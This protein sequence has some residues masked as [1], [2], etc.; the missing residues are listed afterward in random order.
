MKPHLFWIVLAG[1]VAPGLSTVF[2]TAEV[3]VVGGDQGRSWAGGGGTIPAVVIRT[4][5]SV[6]QTNAL[7]GVIDFN[8]EGRPN[9]IFPQRA[10]VT[11]NIAEGIAERGGD[12]G[13]NV[14]QIRGSLGRIIDDDGKTALD[15]RGLVG[16][17]GVRGLQIDMD[18]GARFGVDR[19]K[20]FPRNADPAYP[21][22]EFPFQNDFL[23]G[24]EIFVNDGTPENQS[25][26]V[27][28][29]HTVVLENKN[30]EAVV[31]VR[32]P[33]QYVRFVRLKSLTSVG[34]EIAEFQV[35]G[36]GFVPEARYLS[37]IFDFG[38]L[39]LLG[40]LRWVQAEQGESGFSSARIRTRTGRDPQPVEF[41]KIRPAT[42]QFFRVGGR[43]T[44]TPDVKVPWKW[45]EDVDDTRLSD[46]LETT[47]DNGEIHVSEAIKA[48][49]ELSL[50]EQALIT[51][52][53]ADYKKL[54]VQD[55]GDIR[56]DL[57]NWSGWSPSY[58]AAGIV[59]PEQV[60]DADLGIPIEVESRP[61]RYFQL[62]IDFVS[63]D[64]AAATGIGSL[65]FDFVSP[66]Y[67]EGLVA[68]VL[69][70]KAAV[71]EEM[72]FRFAVLNQ[73]R[74]G[75]DQGFDR[76]EI[77]TPLRVT[78]IGRIQIRRPDGTL[79]EVD[80][81][82]ADPESLPASDNGFAVTAVR[83]DGFVLAFP[84]IEEDGTTLTV[85]FR[86]TVL[87]F[88]TRFNGRA[89]NSAAS[90]T[91]AQVVAG[92]NAA[93]LSFAELDDPDT[94]P[95]GTLIPENLS[96][97]VPLIKDLLINVRAEPAVF[98][99]NGDG[100]NDRSFMRYDITNIARLT[101]LKVHIFDLS[102][103]LVRRLYEDGD[104]S[105]RFARPWDGRDDSGR[106]VP[107]GQYVVRVVLEAGTGEEKAL[108][109]VGVVY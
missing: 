97:D 100:V 92:G 41:T 74:A 3:I 21:A 28:I 61:R 62:A 109:A 43:P 6:E 77:D 49:E 7:G 11:R 99:P 81:S 36:T 60:E 106:L 78:S 12:L 95:L 15:L 5:Q 102:G 58:P 38:D 34:F 29:W 54:R 87:R 42:E 91:V 18:L 39:A 48:F 51:L 65:A 55:R 44:P 53:E 73:S 84:L 35:F 104:Q 32:I 75:R 37:N 45:A 40:N 56:D 50:E 1:S 23:R 82:S 19:F 67:A 85:E 71:G 10:D 107:P 90:A 31:D 96:V 2:S 20:F 22:P 25:Q 83:D 94:Q 105:G 70:R 4:A 66:P 13:S 30:E 63:Q 76:F 16:S 59:A 24:F 72:A 108:G 88:A 14:I 80:F 68:E 79:Q 93:D 26:G 46:L 103:R 98:S 86:S 69:P 47:L 89:L 52:E 33:P 8:P 17:I 27:P 101:P 57:I 64:F 9:W